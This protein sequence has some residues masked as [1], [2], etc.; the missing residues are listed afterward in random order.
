MDGMLARLTLTATL[1]LLT[2]GIARAEF[3]NFSFSYTRWVHS[4]NDPSLTTVSL[5]VRSHET[6]IGQAELGGGPLPLDPLKLRVHSGPPDAPCR[7]ATSTTS[8]ASLSA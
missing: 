8:P 5:E 1:A 2:A 3:V 6:M 7:P 4:P